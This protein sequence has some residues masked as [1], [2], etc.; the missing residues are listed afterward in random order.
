MVKPDLV[1]ARLDK[2]FPW[3]GGTTTLVLMYSCTFG[4]YSE[5]LMQL[6]SVVKS[7]LWSS[8]ITESFEIASSL[9]SALVFEISASSV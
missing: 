4:W 7:W 5:P 1:E 2:G 9:V 8:A 6:K 3:L